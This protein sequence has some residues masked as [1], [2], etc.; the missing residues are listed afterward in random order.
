MLAHQKRAWHLT[1]GGYKIS[2]GVA[3]NWTGIWS[4]LWAVSPAYGT[5]NFLMR[6]NT[7][8][9]FYINDFKMTKSE[10]IFNICYLAYYSQSISCCYV[11]VFWKFC[12]YLI[13]F[14]TELVLAGYLTKYWIMTAT[15]PSFC[16]RYLHSNNIVVVPEGK[17]TYNS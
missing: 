8:W 2:H 7:L 13:S 16:H 14:Q 1:E 11:C 5:R 15:F 4:N 6:L 17:H 12:L 9:F 3:E 10:D